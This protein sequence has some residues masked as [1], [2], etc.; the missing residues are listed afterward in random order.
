MTNAHLLSLGS[1][2]AVLVFGSLALSFDD[3]AFHGIRKAV[4]GTASL[5]WL[6]D[7]LSGLADDCE[8]VLAAIP[9]LKQADEQT[10]AR[11]QLLDLRDALATGRSV[12]ACGED[13]VGGR[14]PNALLVPLVV[15]SQLAQFV[16]LLDH[17]DWTHEAFVQQGDRETVGL[18]TG[19]LAAFAV[20]ASHSQSDMEKYGAAAV[21]LG[22]LVGLAADAID[23]KKGPSKSL[24]VGWNSAETHD[25]M[26]RTLEEFPGAYVSVAYDENRATVTAPSFAVPQLRS[27][28]RTVGL[29]ASEINLHGR[30]HSADNSVVLEHLL[31]FCDRHAEFQLPDASTAALAT[32]S[33]DPSRQRVTQGAL[34][35][36]ALQAITVHSPEWYR[37]LD[38]TLASK[39]ESTL[40]LS[41]GTERC[42]PPSILRKANGRLVHLADAQFQSLTGG[43][44]GDQQHDGYVER[45]WRA[46]DIAVV[47][48]AC[49]L[50]G[51]D[52]VTAFWDLLV[53]AK[54]QHQEI[55]AGSHPRFDFRDTPTR[56][57]DDVGIRG[58]RWFANLVSAVDQFDHRFFKKSP[59]E[60]ASM[61][62]AQRLL[63]QVAYQAVEQSGW[64]NQPAHGDADRN[65]VGVFLG[66]T[67]NDYQANAASQPANA[68]TTTGNLQ[69][70]LAGKVSHHFGWTGPAMVVDTA[71]SGSLVAIHQACRALASGECSAAL[72]GGSHVMTQPA[73]FQNL[74]A[75]QFLSPTGQC[76]PFD[77]AAD[78]YC[79]GEGV[80]AVFLKRMDRAVADGDAILGVIAATAVQQNENCTPI[81]VPNVPSLADLFRTVTARAGV[82]PSQVSVVEAHG[83]GTPVGDPAEYASIKEV[84]GAAN[85]PP[86]RP[87]MLGSVKGLVGHLEGTSG[88]VA[89]IKLL[90]MLH[91]GL[92]PPQAS[93]TRI[94]PAIGAKPADNI[95]IPT[96]QQPWKAEFRIALINNYGASGSNAS[97][98]LTQP[99]ALGFGLKKT[100]MP[101][102]TK[103]PFWLSAHDNDGLRRRASALRRY[104]NRIRGR[105]SLANLSYNVA[106]QNNRALDHRAL[107]S[108]SSL[109]ELDQKLGGLQE[110][111]GEAKPS[112]NK[113]VVLCFGGQVSVSVGLDRQVYEQTAILR[114]HIDRVDAVARSLGIANSIIPDLLD[115]APCKD[116]V[117][118]QLALFA[119]Q[120]ACAQSW[121]DSGLRPVAVV[122]HSFGELTALCIAQVLSLEDAVRMIAGRAAVIR[123]AWGQDRGAMMAV[124]EAPLADV[125]RLILEANSKHSSSPASIACYNGPRSFTIAGSTAAI[126]AVAETLAKSALAGIRTKRLDVSNAFHCAL[127]DGLVDR[128][129]QSAQGLTFREP[130]IPVER[131]VEKPAPA[132]SKLGPRFVAEHM[133]SPVYFHHALERLAARH[134]PSSL[135][136]LEA[137]SNSTVT[138]MA[139]RALAGNAHA[140]D[141]HYFQAVNITNC[142]DGCDRLVDTTMGLWRAGVEVR[143]W[144]H[145]PLQARASADIGPLLLPPYPFDPDARHWIDLKVPPKHAPALPAPEEPKGQVEKEEKG[146]VLFAGYQDGSSETAARFRINTSAARFEELLAGHMTIQTAPICPAT[147]QIG[148]VVEGLGRIRPAYNGRRDGGFDFTPQFQDIQ[149]QSPVCA[150]TSRDTWIEARREAPGAGGKGAAD[151]WRFEVFSTEKHETNN[152]MLHTTGCVVFMPTGDA[153]LQPELAYFARLFGHSRAADLLAHPQDADEVLARRTIYRLFA[154]IVDYGDEYRG[155]HKMIG[156]GIEAAG[157]VVPTR[158]KTDESSV[159]AFDPHLSDAFCQVAGVWANF[160]TAR[161]PSDAYLANGIGQWFRAPARDT[162]PA[163][164]HVFATTQRES[165]RVLLSDVFVFD[166]ADGSLVEVLLGIKYVQIPKAAMSKLLRRLS[167]PRW[168]ASSASS[169]ST[170]AEPVASAPASDT[171]AAA[172]SPVVAV[173]HE[174]PPASTSTSMPQ[175][176]QQVVVEKTGPKTS[177]T[178][179]LAR[180]KTIIA[181]LSGLDVSDIK[182]DSELADLGIDS[183]VG[184]EL[185]NELETAFHISLAESDIQ[186]VMDIPGLMKCLLAT[187]GGADTGEAGESNGSNS[188]SSSSSSPYASSSPRTATGQPSTP[189]SLELAADDEGQNCATPPSTLLSVDVFMGA[190]D[191]VKAKTDARIAEVGQTRYV[192]EALPLQDELTA[193][194]TLEAFE[195]LGAGIRTAAPGQRLARIP[196]GAQHEQLVTYLYRML[197]TLTQTV[198]VDRHDDGP[199]NGKGNGSV[200]ITRTA[201]PLPPR[202]SRAVLEELQARFPDQATANDLTY[203]AGNNLA[204][205]LSGAT[206]GVKL[207]FGNPRG[208]ELAAG[209]YGDWPLNRA[210]YAGLEDLLARILLQRQGTGPLRVLEMGAGTGGTTKHLVPLLARLGVPVVYTMT[211]L[212]PSLMAQARKTWGTR[213]PW[214]R[215]AVH[216][217]ETAPAAGSELAGSQHIVIAS[218]AVHATR[219]LRRSLECIRAVLRPDDG[220]LCL[221]EMTRPMFWVDLVFG[222]FD[223]WWMY[224]D[225]REHVIAHEETWEA[226]LHSAGYGR[227]DWIDGASQESKIWKLI[228][229]A[230]NSQSRRERPSL[231]PA[232]SLAT[233]PQEG[234]PPDCQ[235]HERAVAGYVAELTA[236]WDAPLSVVASEDRGTNTNSGY[237][238]CILITGGTGGLGS[239]LVASALARPDV[240]RVV[241][242]NRRNNKQEARQRQL[243]SLLDKGTGLCAADIDSFADRLD[244]L[245]TDL[246]KPNLGLNA[247]EYARLANTVTH[248]VHNAWLMHSK[249][250]LKR[251]EPQLRIMA[252]MI[253]LARDASVRRGPGAG[254]VTF[255]LVSSIAVVGHHPLRT[256]R[257]FVPEERMAVAS[258]LPTGYGLAKYAC[259]RMLDA[260]L[261]AYPDRFRASAVR[262]GQIAGSTANGYWNPA[263]HVSFLIKSSQ[264][265]HRLPDFG[266]GSTLGWTPVDAMAGTLLDILLQPDSVRLHPIYHIENPVRQAWTDMMDVLAAALDIPGTLPF[267]EWMRRVREWPVAADNTA[268]GANPAYLLAAF[269]DDN[270]VRMSCGGL[271]MATAKARQHSPTLARLGAV[272]DETARLF[273]KKWRDIGFLA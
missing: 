114:K 76:K 69:G 167:D 162:P 46:G 226:A 175:P 54:P 3:D 107:L 40:L 152:K 263:E 201:V 75:G 111:Q 142:D 259:E 9:N 133:R 241:C 154:E 209:V 21:R 70:F 53:S 11:E 126:D 125:Q 56:S 72:A 265:L 161:S 269:L 121:L 184:M 211:D 151:A 108:A 7:A 219:S 100:A 49:K 143:H 52:D 134:A 16:A 243:Q 199:A 168:L 130:V 264:T 74:A 59:R 273:V 31:E 81:F 173:R 83:T 233:Q 63:L 139:S 272:T 129:E 213:Y 101:A 214:M 267:G 174:P 67:G 94:N 112:G 122:G 150:S 217:I 248:V 247:E 115:R 117:R 245:E 215:F 240:A 113:A 223:G 64:L 190:F 131:A 26:M 135:V 261:H 44:P 28:L 51:A 87:L 128:L 166:A 103:H 13:N 80:G 182:P 187:L 191:A 55:G 57:A 47:G 145:D 45:L 42:V 50:P 24:S 192:A 38:A 8:T 155:L 136:F 250:P 62:P 10:Q 164:L 220:Y 116:P 237:G 95:T 157:V 22:M 160:M 18:C 25:A 77:A 137:G 171:N 37:I 225:G 159:V 266:A 268:D 91:V 239:H 60:S 153:A 92:V 227:V 185:I 203:Y 198:K 262:L 132:G 270:F 260:T 218:N 98:V 193:A 216:D 144:G 255:Q 127:V 178:E 148:L 221:V 12:R 102:G 231:L 86:E 146:L 82:R 176:S 200:T 109:D 138:H 99:P 163:E 84:L 106:R 23:A 229:A 43:K 85:R 252:N 30:F 110:G 181:D 61:D 234:V 189:S 79:R 123:D 172:P 271:L 88:V 124:S 257:P 17:S 236:G 141:A 2:P 93:F 197:E 5:A 1:G 222:L 235:D 249:W 39:P 238:K 65:N 208:R 48:M 120:Y 149:Y 186:A 210:T 96:K 66:T 78:G 105:H 251:F 71:C 258:V 33:N 195:E 68:F 224:E 196:H 194:L 165:D 140:R 256:G 27:M 73:W 158:R 169:S 20:A 212:S 179:V 41:L 242:L 253:A 147:V 170:A 29:T 19:L 104:I 177:S 206:D 34:H 15:A 207:I 89:L 244:V 14:L 35:A 4:A 36:H 228:V 205:V 202:T 90:L 118:L 97:A 6:S 232:A 254:P 58:R 119:L 183:L 230:A 188:P 246:S 156:R 32:R 180:V 204:R